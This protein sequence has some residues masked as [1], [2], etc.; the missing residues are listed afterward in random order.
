MAENK[1]SKAATLKALPAGV[2]YESRVN[3]PLTTTTLT[4]QGETLL[5]KSV[6]MGPI[7]RSGPHEEMPHVTSLRAL[8]EEILS[9]T[10]HL[11]MCV[12]FENKEA[13]DQ[14]LKKLATALGAPAMTEGLWNEFVE[15]ANAKEV[16]GLYGYVYKQRLA[17][18][19]ECKMM[20]FC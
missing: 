6:E 3:G 8:G 5:E 19:V 10:L 20:P 18:P 15:V 4:V 14:A 12:H 11:K 13:L 9:T 7:T 16:Q 17:M 2:V 1:R